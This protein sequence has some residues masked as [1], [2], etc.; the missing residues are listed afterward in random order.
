MHTY[1]LYQ[2]N[3]KKYLNVCEGK[4]VL[5]IGPLDGRITSVIEDFNPA[6]ITLVEASEAAT[7][8]LEKKFPN[9]SVINQD[10]YHYL[11]Q[12]HS[13]DVV[14]CTGV[15]YHMHSPIY[16]LELIA[17]RINP[18]YLV[19]ESIFINNSESI[20]ND[21]TRFSCVVSDEIDNIPGNRQTLDNWKSAKVKML[22][23]VELM[24][25]IM[26]NLNYEIVSEEK[27]DTNQFNMNSK[28]NAHLFV[29][30]KI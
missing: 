29:F 30:K 12:T 13:F 21:I 1:K 8:M 7:S 11:E 10:I 14:I 23:S 2:E 20:K 28:R 18:E 6:N 24:K 26:T 19:L 16:L 17:N 25:K 4:T 3:F 5:E 22:F 9:Y 15:L 27:Y